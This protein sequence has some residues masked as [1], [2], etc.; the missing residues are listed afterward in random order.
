MVLGAPISLILSNQSRSSLAVELSLA[1][2]RVL[3]AAS[4]V[5]LP[6]QRHGLSSSLMPATTMRPTATLV[7]NRVAMALLR[8][9]QLMEAKGVMAS[10]RIF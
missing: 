3:E 9:A 2:L 5:A 4:S 1:S 7:S 8:S 6:F 10:L